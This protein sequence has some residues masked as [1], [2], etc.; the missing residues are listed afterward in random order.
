MRRSCGC[1]TAKCTDCYRKDC[2]C[3]TH[4]AVYGVSHNPEARPS[5]M[6][7]QLFHAHEGTRGRV[8]QRQNMEG[9]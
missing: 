9:V 3:W 5:P 7:A 2:A 4:Q 8:R 6:V 1:G